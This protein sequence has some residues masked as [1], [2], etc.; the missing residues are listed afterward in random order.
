MNEEAKGIPSRKKYGDV[1]KIPL[2]KLLTYVDQLHKAERAGLHHDIRFGD[3][4][5]Y[6]WAGKKGLPQPGG[7]HTLFQQPL[8]TPEYAEFEGKIPS[9]YGKGTVKTHDRGS[10]FVTEATPNKI[11][12]VLAHRK[13]P[14]YYTMIKL[15]GERR[16]WLIINHTPTSPEKVVGSKEAFKK[17]HLGVIPAERVKEV[18]DGVVEGKIDGASGLFKLKEDAVD[19]LSFRIGKDNRPIMHTERFFG[20]SSNK[21]K[22]PKKF[23]NRVARGEIY[24]ADKEGKPQSAQTTSPLLNMSLENSLKAQ[25]ERGLSLRAALFGFADRPLNYPER[26]GELNEILK[27]LPKEKFGR[28]S[29]AHSPEEAEKLWKDISEGKHPETDEGV[30]AYPKEGNPVKVKLRPDY[31]VKITDVFPGEGK[32]KGSAGGI[33]YEGGGRVGTGFDDSYRKWLWDN[34]D[35]IKGRIARITSTK[36]LPSGKY[37]QPSF[38]SLHEDYPTKKASQSLFTPDYTPQQLKEMGAYREVYGPKGTP[39]LASLSEWPEHWYHEADPWGWLQWYDR[40]SRG[41]RIDDDARQIKRWRAFKARHGGRMFQ[42]NPTPRRAFALRN[43][44]IDPVKLLED[45]EKREQLAKAMEIYKNKAY[46]KPMNNLKKAFVEGYQKRAAE[47]GIPLEGLRT[48]LF[49]NDLTQVMTPEDAELVRNNINYFQR[50]SPGVIPSAVS[51]GVLGNLMSGLTR[52]FGPTSGRA[53]L[54]GTGL[55]ATALPLIQHLTRTSKKTEEDVLHNAR[56]LIER[57]RTKEKNKKPTV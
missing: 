33:E 36:Q 11:K 21:I 57:A 23:Q 42:E 30:V 28:P 52:P 6:S 54:I 4:E 10:A 16:P 47:V 9:G 18:M 24:S 56:G 37:Y 19:V 5:L 43:W 32:Y 45:P 13:N 29:V 48:G 55:G 17:K 49:G 15:E 34:R 7:K 14:E 26:E 3:R 31:D 35:S 50:T 44:G 41:R 39:R 51:G 1:E 40:Y 38:V 8:H 46:N 53:K 2:R 25:E 22:I 12:F 20:T 27:Y